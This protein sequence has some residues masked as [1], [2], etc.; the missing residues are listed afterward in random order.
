MDPQSE[1]IYVKQVVDTWGRWGDRLYILG[2]ATLFFVGGRVL[3]P[4]T[5]KGDPDMRIAAIEKLMETNAKEINSFAGQVNGR[6]AQ[7]EQKLGVAAPKPAAAPEPP[8]Q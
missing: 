8:K 5:A 4:A 2:L 1:K 7:L 3:P 6:L